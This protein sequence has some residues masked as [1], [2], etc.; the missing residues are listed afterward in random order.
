VTGGTEGGSEAE[1]RAGQGAAG[2]SEVDAVMQLAVQQR[3]NTDS[4][5]AIFCI[6]MS[7]D[8]YVRALNYGA[9]FCRVIFTCPN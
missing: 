6:L 9:R 2:A 5:R 7:A 1:R 4:R 8:D 3:M